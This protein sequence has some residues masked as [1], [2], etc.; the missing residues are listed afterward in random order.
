[1]QS[2]AWRI[3]MCF[4]LLLFAPSVSGQ[5]QE[6]SPRHALII[7][8]KN[9]P[10]AVGRLNNP[11][12]DAKLIKEALIAV[13]FQDANIEVVYDQKRT[14]I[15]TAIERY[16]RRLGQAGSD[17]I[18]FLYY[19]GHGAAKPNTNRNYIIPVGVPAP[20]EVTATVAV[21]VTDSPKTVVS[22]SKP[23]TV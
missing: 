7:A 6:A 18:G 21:K 1:M 5:A 2:T 9:Y 14:E 20:G 23:E 15:L 16:A 10:D 19:S 4:A 22:Q 8:N 3:L 13:G 12:K 11:H 17:A